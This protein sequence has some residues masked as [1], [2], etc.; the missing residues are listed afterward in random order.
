MSVD[1]SFSEYV[2][3]RWELLVRAAVLMGRSRADAE[4]LVQTTLAKLYVHWSRASRAN[5][6][7]SYVYSALLNQSRS[8]FRR[9]WRGEVAV[10]AVPESVRTVSLDV[11][12]VLV[13]QQALSR[14]SAEHR[15]VVVTRHF[16]DLSEADSAAVLGIPVGT[17]KSRLARALANLSS[18]P[19]LQ[20]LSRS[21]SQA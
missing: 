4:D 5:S 13:V 21:R 2:E 9:R 8:S 11:D 7:D 18:D 10:E 20:S 15:A 3:A 17:V 6:V 19:Q 14:L 12:D 1:E 16:L